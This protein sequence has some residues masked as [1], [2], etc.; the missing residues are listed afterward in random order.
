MKT[1]KL[2]MPVLLAFLFGF[3]LSCK[4]DD[5][6]MP[7]P[8]I[9][10]PSKTLNIESFAT[11][12][13]LVITTNYEWTATHPEADT[14]CKL[15]KDKEKLHIALEWNTDTVERSTRVVVTVEAA[16]MRKEDYID[17]VQK[18][19]DRTAVS[20][21]ADK[22]TFD[23]DGETKSVMILAN[24]PDYTWKLSVIDSVGKP[25]A[26]E[27]DWCSVER[28]GFKLNLT[29]VENTDFTDRWA[30]LE[31]IAGQGSNL[32]SAFLTI[33]Q[34]AQQPRINMQDTIVLPAT[35]E[36]VR[37]EVIT[38]QPTWT[39]SE[40][41]LDSKYVSVER[42]EGED[43]LVLKG[44]NFAISPYIGTLRIDAGE[45][46]NR[47]FKNV[48]VK[49]EASPAAAVSIEKGNVTFKNEGGTIELAVTANLPGWTYEVST[50]ASWLTVV[51]E[52]N[53]LKLTTLAGGE[54]LR[55]AVLTLK[56]GDALNS[57]T[58]EVKV[59]QAGT[60]PFVSISISSL[61]LDGN[62][63]EQFVEV[64]SNTGDWKP[65]PSEGAAW[66]HF[67]MDGTKLYVSADVLEAGSRSTT[68]TVGTGELGMDVPVVLT[69]NQTKPY[70]VWDYYVL[71][72]EKIGIVFEV[73]D[74]GMH[75]KVV[76]LKAEHSCR[77]RFS[78]L[79]NA[80][81]VVATNMA[82]GYENMKAMKA[83]GNLEKN[84]PAAAWCD[85]QNDEKGAPGWYLPAYEE[86][87]SLELMYFDGERRE[88]HDDFPTDKA[89]AARERFNQMLSDAGGMPLIIAYDDTEE[90]GYLRNLMSSTEVLKEGI[91]T[92][93]TVTY[94]VETNWGY[95]VRMARD[96]NNGFP[97]DGAAIRPILAF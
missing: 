39:Y 54:N 57:A 43:A 59:M 30:Q 32:N 2:M 4:D 89:T 60:K 21:S 71:N 10:I 17:V 34:Q 12:T 68:I 93:R 46:V 1:L 28:E 67:R 76:S 42:I 77:V 81:P 37:L 23:M 56:V 3:L 84:Y 73:S 97:D 36:A 5:E 86:L 24:M 47:I 31:V 20:L 49:K 15:T 35:N 11:D 48:V 82:D 80:D 58:T 45:G 27:V 40:L 92:G 64:F 79:Q 63:T 70:K 74:G 29:A 62:G 51:A 61:S 50:D 33:Y 96:C 55:E 14:W 95:E 6:S 90:S 19:S 52:G 44:M 18:A 16:G 85:T 91:H 26:G 65:T 69:V 38:N 7:E 83:L 22:L 8:T 88:D 9:S 41:G 78:N 13:T 66:C 75:G 72:G 87:K 25:I 53:K 94:Y